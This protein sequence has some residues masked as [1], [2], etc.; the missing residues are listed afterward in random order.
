MR[1]LAA[2]TVIVMLVVCATAQEEKQV[3]LASYGR[4][5]IVVVGEFSEQAGLELVTRGVVWEDTEETCVLAVNEMSPA[6]TAEL[7]AFATGMPMRVD[8]QALIVGDVNGGVVKGY[9]VSVLAGAYVEYVNNYAAPKQPNPMEELE[10]QDSTAAE[11]LAGTIGYILH[12]PYHAELMPS[13]VGDRILMTLP[14]E[15]HTRVREFLDLLMSEKGGESRA[16]ADERAVRET[17]AKTKFSGDLTATPVSSVVLGICRTAK[18]NVALGAGIAMVGADWHID[19][20][21]KEEVTALEALSN[22]MGRLEKDD[23]FLSL[24]SCNGAAT[25]EITDL[26]VWSGYRVYDIRDLLKKLN[27]SYQRQRTA[28]GKDGGFDG[29]LKQAGGSEVVV[30]AIFDQLEIQ[31]LDARVESFGSKVI[32]RGSAQS[33]DAATTILKEMGWEPPKE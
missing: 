13:V 27:A 1:T 25:V 3:S 8:G 21:V 23:L 10:L 32:V 26:N 22:L 2:F 29:D 9:D 19:F 5:S 18:L 31:N 6:A 28:G 20:V 16:L 33:V 17:L 24:S 15:G 7:L 12:H 30:G 11:H 14:A 4:A